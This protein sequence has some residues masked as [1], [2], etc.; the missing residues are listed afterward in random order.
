MSKYI[1]FL[2][3]LIQAV[4]FAQPTASPT[5]IQIPLYNNAGIYLFAILFLFLM[6]VVVAY[7][8]RRAKL[9]ISQ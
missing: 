7:Q 9:Q 4:V 8:L 2:L 3:T 5:Q 6:I 1:A